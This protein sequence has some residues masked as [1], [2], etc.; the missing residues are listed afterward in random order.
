MRVGYCIKR[1]YVLA[2]DK[3]N[4]V[5]TVFLKPQ[6]FYFNFLMQE[7]GFDAAIEAFP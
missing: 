6:M 2:R 4:V 3:I 5:L 7:Q 1:K